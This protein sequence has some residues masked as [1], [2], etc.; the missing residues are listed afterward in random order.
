M[1]AD[2]SFVW[3]GVFWPQADRRPLASAMQSSRSTDAKDRR[4]QRDW[5]IRFG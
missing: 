2:L 5:A 3:A 4:K 1:F